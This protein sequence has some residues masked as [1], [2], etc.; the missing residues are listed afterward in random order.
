MT[1]LASTTPVAVLGAGLTGMSAAFHLAKAGVPH[2]IFERRDSPGGHV[3]TR[4][5]SGYRFDVTGHRPSYEGR[6]IDAQSTQ[7]RVDLVGEFLLANDSHGR[8]LSG[9]LETG[10]EFDNLTVIRML[11]GTSDAFIAF[12]SLLG[13][14]VTF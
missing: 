5:D 1:R 12:Q 4:E 6:R 14:R 3:I 8:T 7:G 9:V 11:F 13:A 10:V 2:R